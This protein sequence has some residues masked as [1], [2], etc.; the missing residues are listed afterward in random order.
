MTATNMCSNFGG[1]RFSPPKELTLLLGR[2]PQRKHPQE[3][4]IAVN[5]FE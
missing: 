2:L 1:F 4:T 5:L 3:R